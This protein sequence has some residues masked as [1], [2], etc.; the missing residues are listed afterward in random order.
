MLKSNNERVRMRL[1]NR[2]RKLYPCQQINC[3]LGTVEQ[4]IQLHTSLFKRSLSKATAYAKRS[5]YEAGFVLWIACHLFDL[6]K[7]NPFCFYC[8]K[9]FNGSDFMGS[10][11]QLEHFIPRSRRRVPPALDSIQERAYTAHHPHRIV[12]ACPNATESNQICRT[13]SFCRSFTMRTHS[14]GL[15][16][17]DL[18][19][20]RN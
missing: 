18:I 4:R 1:I 6:M 12:L 17:M 11:V 2:V 20:E 13:R 10:E 5:S 14:S 15:V 16:D 3:S 9:S 8:G 7:K 19:E